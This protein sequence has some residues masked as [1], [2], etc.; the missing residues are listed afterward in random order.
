MDGPPESPGSRLASELGLDSKDKEVINSFLFTRNLQ[1]GR[2]LIEAFHA[3]FPGLTPDA[4]QKIARIWQAQLTDGYVIEGAFNIINRLAAA[5]YRLGIISNIWKPY[6]TCFKNLFSN[7]MEHFKVIILSYKVGTTKPDASIFKRAMAK[8]GLYDQTRGMVAPERACMVGDSYYHDVA[9]A[10][11]LGMR[12]VWIL[13]N[14]GR[15]LPFMRDVL[16]KKK[17]SPDITVPALDE[18]LGDKFKMLRTL[19]D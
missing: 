14:Q 11:K 17:L 8:F 4:D 18:L 1:S 6:F 13:Q 5:G 12:T 9:P 19:M 16:L 7:Y 10:V 2:E 3:H 15:E